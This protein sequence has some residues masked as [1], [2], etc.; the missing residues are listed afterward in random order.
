HVR[1][2]HRGVAAEIH[3]HRRCEPAQMVAILPR[4][5]LPRDQEG[6]LREIHFARHVAHPLLGRRL[7][8]YA[9]RRGISRKRAVGKSIHLDDSNSHNL[10]GY[11]IFETKPA[12][13]ES[14]Y[15]MLSRFARMVLAVRSEEHT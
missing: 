9:H 2:G 7:A 3:F 4:G 13:A 14:N 12:M 10:A 15:Q 11:R 1:A 8:E 5:D 6:G